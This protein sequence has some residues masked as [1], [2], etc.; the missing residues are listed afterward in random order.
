[1]TRTELQDEITALGK[2]AYGSDEYFIAA[3]LMF[4]A[5][6]VSDGDDEQL[7]EL[8]RARFEAQQATKRN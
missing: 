4:V 2:R 5:S 1:M 6:A 8:L 7:A 3:C